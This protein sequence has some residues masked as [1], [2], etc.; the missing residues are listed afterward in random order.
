[1]KVVEVT[2]IEVIYAFFHAGFGRR[3]KVPIHLLLKSRDIQVTRLFYEGALDF[4]VSDSEESTC[5]VEKEGGSIIFSA[6]E[7]W[8]GEPVCTGTVYFFVED[9]VGYY[10]SV[11][12][13]V[14]VL[15]PLEEMSYGTKE[16]GIKDCNGYCLAFA[17][18]I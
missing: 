7:L 2:G 13:K 11:K 16:F 3:F 17:Q 1:M 10:E 12:D 4:D 6:T 18:R 15:W 5:T 9:V 8:S 14:T